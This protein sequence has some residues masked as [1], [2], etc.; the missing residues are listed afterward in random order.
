MTS[1]IKDKQT[2][3]DNIIR[4]W[5]KGYQPQLKEYSY[6]I[7]DIEGTIPPELQGTFFRN[8]P[9]ALEINGQNIGHPFD[10]DGMV[11][12]FTFN[13]GRV[14]FKN[15]YVRTEGY[16]KEQAAGKIL[17]RGFGTQKSGGWLANFGDTKFKNAANTS[18]IYWGGK[19][20]TMWEGGQPH[21]L[22]PE[23]LETVGLDDLNG[24]LKSGQPFSAHPRIINDVFVNFGVKGI[25]SQSLTIFELDQQ[26]NTLTEHSHPLK[27]FAFLHDMLVTDNYYIFIQNPFKVEGLP[28][29]LGFK[30]IEQCFDF[31]PQEPSRIMVISRHG[32][33]EMKV[34]EAE[35]FFGF[36][37]GNAWEKDGKIY[38]ETVLYDAFPKTKGGE[39]DFNKFTIDSFTKGELWKL[40]L[41]LDEQT[42]TREKVSEVSCEFPS[43]H[44]KWVGKEHRYLYM[45]I[46]FTAT[47]K[48]PLQAIM[49]LDKQSGE[50]QIWGQDL[51][52]FPGEPLFIPRPDGV[53]EDEG[54]LLSLVYDPAIHRSYL[55][56]LDAKNINQEIAKL[57]LTHHIPHGFHGTWTN[58]IFT[59]EK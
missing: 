58:Q 49:K 43:V 27:G 57:S 2:K 25:T 15:R 32:D 40:E 47:G 22:I 19:L 11:C 41:S 20:W 35:P 5:A 59:E 6:W 7:D 53:A 14:H 17:Y 28:F 23:T 50:T 3:E 51:N 12:A 48:G 9:G 30:S 52:I 55:I 29:V 45:N 36:H 54:W 33:H 8:G 44:P 18:V 42:V 26:G 38:L 31:N 16:I 46:T 1:V 10:G 37:H 39:L 56:I 21:Q 24:L 4:D 34:L 13:Q